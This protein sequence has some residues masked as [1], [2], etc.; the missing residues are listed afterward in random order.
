MMFCGICQNDLNK[1][2]CSDLNER[3]DSLASS[4]HFVFRKDKTCGKHYSQCH[5][6]DPVWVRSDNDELLVLGKGEHWE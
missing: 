4:D 2:V 3:L 1:C 6:K 5:C